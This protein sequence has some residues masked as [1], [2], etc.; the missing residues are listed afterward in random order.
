MIVVKGNNF[1]FLNDNKIVQSKINEIYINGN[2]IYIGS[3]LGVGYYEADKWIEIKS[4]KNQSIGSVKS[5][6][7]AVNNNNNVLFVG[8]LRGLFVFDGKNS[9][10][11][12]Q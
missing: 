10:H 12:N 8:T 3:E 11:L 5:I 7:V 9:L 2:K 1:K 6:E 4:S